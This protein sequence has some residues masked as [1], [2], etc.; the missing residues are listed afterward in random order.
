MPARNALRHDYAA[1]RQ[2]KN[3]MIVGQHAGSR[4]SVLYNTA[5]PFK[6]K[7]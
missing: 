2:S 5:Q 3:Q 7:I 4:V 6:S 1:M